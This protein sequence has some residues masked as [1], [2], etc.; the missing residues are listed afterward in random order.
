MQ[1]IKYK[2]IDSTNEEAKRLI[3]IGKIDRGGIAI[4]AEEQTG[5]RGRYDRVWHSPKGNLYCSLVFKVKH[6]NPDV[7][8]ICFVAGLAVGRVLYGMLPEGIIKY[9]WPNDVLADGKK[10]S[11]TLLEFHKGYMIV[12]VGINIE[13]YPDNTIYPATSVKNIVKTDCS[14][15]YML[16]NFI[17]QFSNLYETWSKYGF[18]SLQDEWRDHTIHKKGDELT[19]SLISEK[20]PAIYQ[21]IDENGDLEVMVDGVLRKINSGEV[22]W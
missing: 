21:D 16:Q 10:I 12:G 4:I 13:S 19:V 15:E 5:G 8:Q 2:K 22:F 9:K 1:I 6:D 11:G 18:V 20:F 14:V 7:A 3:D 17:N